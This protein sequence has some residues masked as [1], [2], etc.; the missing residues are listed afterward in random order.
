M[1]PFKTH[2]AP[3]R[4][5]MRMRMRMLPRASAASFDPRRSLDRMVNL[6][7]S[8]RPR[9]LSKAI[10]FARGRGFGAFIDEV[11][12]AICLVIMLGAEDDHRKTVA[13]LND[14]GLGSYVIHAIKHTCKGLKPNEPCV[15][16]LY[17]IGDGRYVEW[18]LQKP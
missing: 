13:A 9:D 6:Q 17:N 18:H 1:A 8:L 4:P 7:S 16:P 3:A 15:I 12:D 10:T 5:P 2:G 14:A 11:D